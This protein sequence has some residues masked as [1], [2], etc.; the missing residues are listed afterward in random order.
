MREMGKE[1]EIRDG[2][3]DVEDAPLRPFAFVVANGCYED[4]QRNF[5]KPGGDDTQLR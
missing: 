5:S 4:G 3:R 2:E 1:M